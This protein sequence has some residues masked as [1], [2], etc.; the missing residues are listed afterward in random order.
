MKKLFKVVCILLV[1]IIFISCNVGFLIKNAV[2]KVLE[3]TSSGGIT[4]RVSVASDGSQGNG[5]S[6]QTT[7]SGDG[8][9]VAFVSDASNLVDG[10]TNG[11]GDIFLH[12]TQ[13]GETTLVS[14]ASDGSQ[15]KDHSHDPAISRDGRY[16]AFFSGAPHVNSSNYV[17]GD[18]NTFIGDSNGRG[19]IFLHDSQTGETTLIS[20]AND[21]SQGNDDSEKP[22]ISSNGRYIAFQSDA[23]NLV[24][25]DTN[26]EMDVFL[27]DSQT[28]ETTLISVANDG[29]PGNDWSYDPSISGDGRFVAFV[30][31]ATN[32]VNGAKLGGVF[33]HDTQTGETALVSVAS[34]GSLSNGSDGSPSISEDGRY[35]SFYSDA[36]TLVDE[37][38]NWESDIFLRDIFTDKTTLVS[39]ASDGSQGNSSSLGSSLSG[40]GRYVV[41]ESFASNLDSGDTNGERLDVFLHNTQTDKTTLVSVA[42]DVGQGN[43]LSDRQSISG[44][45]RYVVFTSL[46]NNLVSGDTNETADVYIFDCLGSK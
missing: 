27:H 35:V 18:G 24:N 17:W 8:R 44:D 3:D 41:F 15:G 2:G 33:L 10:D 16:I 39:V 22:S 31:D 37:D 42:S 14:I 34:D 20:V 28:G 25:G 36:T 21:G 6:F 26:E 46:A 38:T 7:I 13:T 1:S 9:Y 40:D 32:L 4:S 11:K 30:S 23:S 19:D 43:S 12:D 5:P 45:G 29:S